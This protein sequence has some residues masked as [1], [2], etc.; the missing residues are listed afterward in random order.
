MEEIARWEGLDLGQCY[1]YS[2]SA[3]DLPML[4]AVGHPVAVNPD[5]RLARHARD[6]GWPIVHFSQRTK[7]VI[8]RA[9]AAAG[10][11]AIAGP[12]FAAGTKYGRRRVV[13]GRAEACASVTLLTVTRFY[14]TTPIYYVN[15]E[16][17]IGHAYTTIVGDAS[18]AGA[19][20]SATTSSSSPARTS[21]AS[22]SS[23][24]RPPP[25]ST[26]RS[27]PTT[28]PR[29][30]AAWK[31][32]EIANDDFIRTTEARHR[33]AVVELLQRC[34]DAGDIEL[35][36]YRGKYCVR[37]EAYYTDDEL[38]PGGLCPIHKLPV[39]ELEEENY[40][41]RLSRYQ[42][43]LLEW[44]D[45]HPGSI[46]PEFRGNEAIGF[47]RSGLRDFSVSRTSV[48]WGIPLPWDPKHVAYVWFDALTNYLSPSGSATAPGTTSSGGPPTCSS[49]A[50]TSSASTACTGRRC[51]SRPDCSRR[52]GARSEVG[53]SSTARRCRRPRATS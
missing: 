11:T 10:A 18:P 28:S 32:L 37:C 31:P 29:F 24:P 41:F 39:D 21:T 51:C 48:S 49:S 23:R 19:G 9:A 47:I 15:D 4:E 50:R 27:S 44:Y 1:A 16:P 26:R 12:P 3:S 33:T 2:D 6:H 25:A 5:G 8:R 14:A 52:R 40:F 38:L 13:G 17:H 35:D 45:A 30:A 22:R 34:Y 43:R 7:S 42:D 46:V 20:C 53:C 36:Y